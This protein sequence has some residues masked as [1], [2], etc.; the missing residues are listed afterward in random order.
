VSAKY[1]IQSLLQETLEE[2]IS[3]ENILSL[4]NTPP[5]HVERPKNPEHGDYSCNLAFQLAPQLKKS[6]Q[7]IG[8]LIISILNNRL[9]KNFIESVTFHPPGFINFKL[10]KTW[11]ATQVN[12]INDEGILFGNS[13]LGKQKKV[14]VEF[15]SVNPT[16]PI[17]VG[18]LRGAVYGSALANILK[19]AGYEVETEYYIN[20]AGTQ[21]DNFSLSIFVRYKELY[22][23]TNEF[24]KE[25]YHGEYIKDLALLVSSQLGDKLL[26]LSQV[27]ACSKILSISLTEVLNLIKSDMTEMN[28]TYDNWFSERSLYESQAFDRIMELLKSAN[29]TKKKDGAIWFLSSNF[30]DDKDKVLI[31]KN[32]TPTYFASD[33]AYHW[34]KFNERHFDWVID[35]WGADHHGHV[36]FMNAILKALNIP[37]NKLSILLYQLVTLKRNNETVRVSKRTGNV[38]TLKELI[39]EVG[40]DPCRYFFLSRAPDTQMD[41][42]IHLAKQQSNENPVYYIQYAYARCSSV[43]G[44]AA[45]M[46][47]DFNNADVS[48]LNSEKELSLIQKMLDLPELI[49]MMSLK[50]EPHKLP[51]YTLE[52]AGKLHLF[53]ETCRII[54]SIEK[55]IPLMK[56]RLKLTN[57][58]AIVL[59][60]CLQLMEMKAPNE[61]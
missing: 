1:T 5:I 42:D 8:E 29:L 18:H 36:P 55:D 48:L 35:I 24:P 60:K 2:M 23:E 53:Y 44:K 39:N 9:N 41:F 25:G 58:C 14:Q 33:V 11:I 16:G 21:I 47:I 27:E 22:G 38:I 51:H 13:N 20:D 32:G 40:T 56:S 3:S 45:A 54:T 57:A 59:K 17:H 61:M 49:E 30:G 37:H 26:K 52:L 7:V 4:D 43:L 31:R 10:T 6:P 50:I 34:N 12:L 15:V 19:A 28:V 46:S